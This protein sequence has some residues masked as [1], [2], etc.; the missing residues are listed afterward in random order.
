MIETASKL[1]DYFPFKLYSSQERRAIE[2]AELIAKIFKITNKPINGMQER[3]WGIYSGKTWDDIKVVLDPMNLN[4]RYNFV[5]QGGESWKDFETR[6]QRALNEV[7][8]TKGNENIVMVSHGGAIRVLMPYL[9]G[10]PKEESFK[11]DPDNASL[12]V[13]EASK[14]GFKRITFN[15]IDH[16]K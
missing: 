16:L 4:D 11:Y 5:P 8:A 2:S 15:N 13:F 6:L 7:L 1:K 3:N 9:L 12:T 14:E 10:V